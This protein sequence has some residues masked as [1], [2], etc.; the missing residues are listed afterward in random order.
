MTLDHNKTKDVIQEMLKSMG[1]GFDTV[2]I[3]SNPDSQH[4]RFAIRTPE[5]SLLIGT[6]GENL[7]ALNYLIKKI[8]T[9]ALAPDTEVKFFIDVNDYHERAL[10]S[11]KAKAKVMS[12]RARSFKV[13]IEMEPMTSYERMLVHSC[14]EGVS[15]VKTESVGEGPL[16][17]VVI[18]YLAS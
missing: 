16:R 9:K 8:V 17:R 12:E 3:I 5:P 18:K 1:I 2:E 4:T 6:K 14:L 10:E 13:D 7:G 11:V 15:D